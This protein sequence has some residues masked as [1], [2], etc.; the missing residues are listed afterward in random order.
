MVWYSHDRPDLA[1]SFVI[2]QDPGTVNILT[3]QDLAWYHKSWFKRNKWRRWKSHIQR[4]YIYV[5]KFKIQCVYAPW[6]ASNSLPVTTRRMRMMV[7]CHTS[8]GCSQLVRAA[9]DFS[10]TRKQKI[11]YQNFSGKL[12]HKADDF[13]ATRSRQVYGNSI[14]RAVPSISARQ[15]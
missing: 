1:K 5:Y 13:P 6:I 9:G 11:F 4:W 12:E 7:D 15:K 10:R 14:F 3:L 2:P 8:S